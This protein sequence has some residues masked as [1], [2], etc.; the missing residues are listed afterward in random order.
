M[1]RRVGPMLLACLALSTT[2]RADGVALTLSTSGYL[3]DSVDHPVTQ[4]GLSLRFSLWNDPASPLDT[5]RVWPATGESECVSSVVGG[6]YTAVLDG[7][8]TS[9]CGAGLTSDQLPGSQPRYLQI[10][11]GDTTLSPRMRIGTVPTAAFA[12]KSADT[13]ALLAVLAQGGAAVNT[14]GNAVDW[15]A[16]KNVPP[17][18]ADG[19][20]ADTTYTAAVGGGL[21]LVTPGNAFGIAPAGVTN[22]MLQHPSV[23]VSAGTGLSGGG[24]VGLGGATTLGLADTSVAAGTYS[25]PTLTVDAQGRLTAASGGTAVT[26]VTAGAGLTGGTISSTGSLGIADSGVT[27]PMLASDPASLARVSGA[28]MAS[29]GGNIGIG[30]ATP[31]A[32][33]SIITNNGSGALLQV[34]NSSST[35]IAYPAITLYNYAGTT[36]G[37][38]YIGLGN[39]GGSATSPTATSAGA[40]LGAI[41]GY[42]YDGTSIVQSARMMMIAESTFGPNANATAITFSPANGGSFAEAMRIKPDGNVGI[43]TTTPQ[44]PL[45][46]NGHILGNPVVARFNATT[47]VSGVGPW[48]WDAQVFNSDATYIARADGNQSIQ[49]LKSGYYEITA[50]VLVFGLSSGQRADVYLQKNGTA[51]EQSLVYPSADGYSKHHVNTVDQ[52]VAGDKLQVVLSQAGSRYA[53]TWCNFNIVRLN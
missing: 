46:V 15:K 1:L 7:S 24:S 47:L 42:G 4:S 22:E 48:T 21:S 39:M 43:G 49:I 45:D 44:A 36:G 38:P 14:T 25:H 53:G 34:E 10:S 50:S 13:Q 51:L 41:I 33:L 17:G 8:K 35:S 26:A 11:V 20:D 40:A 16:L 5:S 37:H 3:L 9:G 18:L 12:T 27:H 30:T 23:T 52:L 31:A 2:A 19:D 32:K 28:A 6:F 29:S